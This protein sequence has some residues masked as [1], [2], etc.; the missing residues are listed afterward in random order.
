MAAVSSLVKLFMLFRTAEASA[1]AVLLRA[2]WLRKGRIL[3]A[4]SLL[5]LLFFAKQ[6]ESADRAQNAERVTASVGREERSLPC[7]AKYFKHNKV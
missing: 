2:C 3:D 4:E 5:L 1:A 7:H 6:A